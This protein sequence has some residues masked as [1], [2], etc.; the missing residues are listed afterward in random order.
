MLSLRVVSLVFFVA[1]LLGLGLIRD[2]S[3]SPGDTALVS[4]DDNGV[5]FNLGSQWPAISGDGRYVAFQSALDTMTPGD[6]N[7]RSDIVVR[8][9]VRNTNILASVDSNGAQS[10]SDSRFPAISAD[11]RYVAFSAGN[12]GDNYGVRGIYV[13][14]LQ[15]N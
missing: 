7:G 2:A 14:D 9:L 1:G 13:R 8:D 15:A 10:A 12:L 3:A 11:G 5:Q 4:I 6:T